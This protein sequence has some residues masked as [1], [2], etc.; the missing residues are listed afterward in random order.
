MNTLIAILGDTYAMIVEKKN[1]FA[2]TQRTKL[3]SDYLYLIELDDIVRQQFLYVVKPVENEDDNNQ[4]EGVVSSI[5]KKIRKSQEQMT[6]EFKLVYE[7]NK[8][9]QE[10]ISKLDGSTGKMIDTSIGKVDDDIKKM[11]TDMKT[12]VDEMKTGM[13]S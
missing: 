4:W 10:K 7:N 2:I 9:I 6:R 13:E 3:Y 11:N 12:R 1:V 8:M 5:K